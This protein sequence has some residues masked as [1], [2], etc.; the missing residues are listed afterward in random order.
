MRDIIRSEVDK[1]NPT[2]DARRALELI[3]ESS[4]RPSEVD[5]AMKITVVGQNG[6]PR[7]IEKEGQNAEFTLQDLLDE[8]RVSHPILF[9]SPVRPDAEA[10][11]GQTSAPAPARTLKEA[12]QTPEKPHRDWLEI[13]SGEPSSPV[14]SPA[15]PGSSAHLPERRGRLRLGGWS[16]NILKTWKNAVATN[17]SAKLDAARDRVSRSADRTRDFFESYRARPLS[18]RPGFALGTVAIVALLGVGAFT[19]LGWDRSSQADINEPT[20]TGALS[21]ARVTNAEPT[22]TG[23][24]NTRALRGV[25]D[26]I[27]TA[28]LSL[29]GEVVRLFGVEWAPGGGKPED[30]TSYLQG[31]EVVCTPATTNDT[32]RCQVGEQDLS[33]VVLFNGGGK[34]TAEAS[35]ELKAAADKAREAQL[36][37]WKPQTQ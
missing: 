28:T 30:L 15:T 13:G 14:N 3:I 29:Q 19:L 24:S 32:Y 37:V 12:F 11:H 17:H 23:S 7:M 31:R 5:G 4:V 36:G 26:V 2:D 6:Q 34:P 33:R 20:V 25:P 1:L 22:T 35:P 27:D 10:M 21:S 9:K 8:L 18:R 16:G